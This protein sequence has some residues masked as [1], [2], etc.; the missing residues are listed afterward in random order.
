MDESVFLD[1]AEGAQRG[2][3]RAPRALAGADVEL[4][5]VPGTGDD[6][7]VHLTLRECRARVRAPVLDRVEL[8]TDVVERDGSDGSVRR[9]NH[10]SQAT[11]NVGCREQREPGAP[12]GPRWR[13]S[14]L[15][16]GSQ[17]AAVGHEVAAS[18]L[19]GEPPILIWRS[20]MARDEGLGETLAPTS[21]VLGCFWLVEVDDDHVDGIRRR[22]VGFH[23]HEIA[24]ARDPLQPTDHHRVGGQREDAARFGQMKRLMSDSAAISMKLAAP[25]GVSR[26]SMKSSFVSP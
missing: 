1:G 2:V 13:Q 11:G 23:Q 6:R 20:E 26:L 7:A 18:A 24:R 9:A 17:R 16:T 25:S 3:G 14:A 19:S 15:E 12:A 10:E 8:P 5:P 22:F 4:A 21:E